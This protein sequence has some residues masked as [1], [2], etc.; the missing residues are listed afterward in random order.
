MHAEGEVS[1]ASVLKDFDPS[2]T[3][4]ILYLVYRVDLLSC[5][6]SLFGTTNRKVETHVR[7]V[8][9]GE[10][11]SDSILAKNGIP[12]MPSQSEGMISF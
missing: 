2:G 6:Y 8:T 9:R 1:V 12:F 4:R 11:K 5:N 3:I 10:V 7:G